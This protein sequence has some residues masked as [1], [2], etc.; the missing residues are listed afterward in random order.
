MELSPL[1]RLALFARRRYRTV[2]AVAAVLVAIAAVLTLRLSFDTDI[3]NLLPRKEPPVKAYIESLADFGSGTLLIVA[4]RIPEGA[5]AEPYETFADELAAR[6][7]R[8]PELKSVEH[9]IGDP[10]EL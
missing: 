2:F 10:E 7:S 6:L 1:Q 3:L 9:R 5:V 8:M 4:I